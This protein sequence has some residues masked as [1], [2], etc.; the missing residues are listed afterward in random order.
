LEKRSPRA[1]TKAD[2]LIALQEEWAILREKNILG[3]LIESMPKH[4]RLVISS[5]GM[6]IKY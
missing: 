2:L 4:V 6:P 1:V 3:I 5:N